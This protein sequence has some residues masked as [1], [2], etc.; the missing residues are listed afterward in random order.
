MIIFTSTEQDD[1]THR[2]S[3]GYESV[4]FAWPNSADASQVLRDYLRG[5]DTNGSDDVVDVT[6]FRLDDNSIVIEHEMLL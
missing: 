3:D 1:S 6:V 5:Y 2:V 4:Y